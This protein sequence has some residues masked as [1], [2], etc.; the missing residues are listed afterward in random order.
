MAKEPKTQPTEVD[1]RAVV[2]AIADPV[3]RSDCQWLLTTMAELSAT[4]PCMWGGEI[5]G[6][7]RY[8][9]RY[10]SGREGEWPRI[11][12]CSR[13]QNIALYIMPGFGAYDGLLARLGKHSHGKSCLYIKRLSDVDREVLREFMQASLAAMAERYPQPVGSDSG[14]AMG[15]GH[16]V[17]SSD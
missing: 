11:G 7:G 13:K 9:Y 6:F 3:R 15:T 2:N 16:C 12:F 8:R 17:Q 5:I 10:E 14:T 4:E 1:P